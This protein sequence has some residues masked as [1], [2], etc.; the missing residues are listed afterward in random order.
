MDTE[1]AAETESKIKGHGEF[2]VSMAHLGLFCVAVF[3]IVLLASTYIP[4]DAIGWQTWIRDEES[5]SANNLLSKLLYS[6]SFVLVVASL[7]MPLLA[8]RRLGKVLGHGEVL[9]LAVAN[10]FYGLA[11]SVAK[12]YLL[13]QI[14]GGIIAV[15]GVRN[16]V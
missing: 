1:A 13:L 7:V 12:F 6:L 2:L 14:A 11:R 8:L 15:E 4:Q 5:S 16:F 9:S 3:G 10:A